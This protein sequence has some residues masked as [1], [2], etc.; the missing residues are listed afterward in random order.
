[1]SDEKAKSSHTVVLIQSNAQA[2][3]RTYLDFETMSAALD[4]ARHACP[5]LAT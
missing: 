4:G 1:M 3:S 2:N 5:A